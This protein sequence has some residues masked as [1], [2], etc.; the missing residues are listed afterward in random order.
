M[1]KNTVYDIIIIGAGPAGT[2]AAILAAKK[3][4][5]VALIDR[6]VFPRDK[7]CGDQI[8]L[9]ALDILINEKIDITPLLQQSVLTGCLQYITNKETVSFDL[10]NSDIKTISC[11]RELFDSFLFNEAIKLIS[12]CHQGIKDL[13]IVEENGLN[14]IHFTDSEKEITLSSKYLIGADGATSFV[15]RTFFSNLRLSHAIATRSYVNYTGNKVFM[16]GFYYNEIAKGGYFWIF[17]V[18]ETT[19]NCGVILFTDDWKKHFKNINDVHF[20]Y[21]KKEEAYISYPEKVNSWQTPFL[22]S[23]EQLTHNSILLIGDAAGLVNPMFGHGIDAAIIS[24]KIAAEHIHKKI[25]NPAANLNAYSG[26]IFETFTKKY[27][28]HEIFRNQE[29]TLDEGF[30]TRFRKYFELKDNITLS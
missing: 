20:F 16:R 15:R 8:I 5:K 18:N 24:A 25:N 13:S 2:T 9:N 28:A 23:K 6:A 10:R 17:P 27:I 3:G 1:Q 12:A 30:E 29:M 11:K 21:A 26:E 22:L 4:L 14:T 19:A 7:I